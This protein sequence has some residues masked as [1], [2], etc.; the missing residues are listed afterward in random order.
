MVQK[1]ERCQACKKR[2]MKVH[3]QASRA[4]T[5][6]YAVDL[7]GECRDKLERGEISFP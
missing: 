1:S 2:K 6:L 7:C 3:I 5:V 4:D